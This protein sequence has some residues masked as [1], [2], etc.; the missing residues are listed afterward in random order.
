[1]KGIDYFSLQWEYFKQH[2][3]EVTQL[4]NMIPVAVRT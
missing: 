1:M 4:C 3:A 2:Q